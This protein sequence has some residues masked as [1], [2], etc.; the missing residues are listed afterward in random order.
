VDAAVF[1]EVRE[2]Y[3]ESRKKRLIKSK[4]KSLNNLG[5]I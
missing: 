5:D 4:R 2:K 1:E 3:E